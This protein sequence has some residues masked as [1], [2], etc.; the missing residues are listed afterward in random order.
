M[1]GRGGA[2]SRTQ[3]ASARAVG[4]AQTAHAREAAPG[5]HP[6][7][8]EHLPSA[9]T[10]KRAHNST[11]TVYSAAPQ[12]QQP[13]PPPLPPGPPPPPP[14]PYLN[15]GYAQPPVPAPHPQY[16]GYGYGVRRKHLPR[17][18]TSSGPAQPARVPLRDGV[19]PLPASTAR[20]RTASTPAEFLQSVSF[21]PS[22]G[23]STVPLRPDRRTAAVRQR[24]PLC[25]PLPPAILRWPSGRACASVLPGRPALQAAPLRLD[26]CATRP[27]ASRGSAR[28]R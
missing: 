12:P 15:Y 17:E 27:P 10:M 24:G 13:P 14:N 23:G 21:V 22:P 4:A 20:P 5:G 18:L 6:R 7:A 3:P 19:R 2:G 11:A 8:N 9:L 26:G 28:I 25:R 1:R 16:P